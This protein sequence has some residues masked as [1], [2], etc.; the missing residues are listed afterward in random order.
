M[1]DQAVFGRSSHARAG[2]SCREVA[3]QF[4]IGVSSVVRQ[5]KRLL[6]RKASERSV[7]SLW[8]RNGVSTPRPLPP[9]RVRK[10]LQGR[11]KWTNLT[12]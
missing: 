8:S 11:G 2:G 1:N 9:E 7:E 12:G 3:Q 6:L 5:V 4:S 10:L